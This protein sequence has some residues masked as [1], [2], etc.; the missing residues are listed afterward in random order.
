M[1]KLTTGILMR[2]TEKMPMVVLAKLFG[3]VCA[4]EP[5]P[6]VAWEPPAH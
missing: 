4:T 2:L 6:A 3:R 5:P 1:E